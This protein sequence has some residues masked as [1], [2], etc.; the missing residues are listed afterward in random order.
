MRRLPLLC[1]KMDLPLSN[2]SHST[3]KLNNQSSKCRPAC[4]HHLNHSPRLLI[5]WFD[6]HLLLLLLLNVFK[7]CENWAFTI[8]RKVN[9]IQTV[10]KKVSFLYSGNFRKVNVASCLIPF[11]CPRAEKYV[12][13]W[14]PAVANCFH[15]KEKTLCCCVLSA[16]PQQSM[17]PLLFLL[18]DWRTTCVIPAYG[19]QAASSKTHVES[20][21][22]TACWPVHTNGKH[23]CFKTC[24]ACVKLPENTVRRPSL[25]FAS[26]CFPQ[27]DR[28]F[29]CTGAVVNHLHCSKDQAVVG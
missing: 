13:K 28:Q 5:Y 23:E 20:R 15:G 3:N 14:R 2:Q 21:V 26:G 29:L 18:F 9:I 19:K 8:K 25:S 12:A 4:F 1:K 22:M 27:Q 16:Q 6:F 11:Y 17:E 24:C 7:T 10:R